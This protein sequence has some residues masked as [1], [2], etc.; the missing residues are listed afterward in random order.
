MN[1]ERTRN[2]LQS[3]DLPEADRLAILGRLDQLWQRIDAEPK[4]TKWQLRNRI[5]D[6]LQWYEEPEEV[7]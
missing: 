5:G 7:K 1:V 4:S 2:S 3:Y 6:R